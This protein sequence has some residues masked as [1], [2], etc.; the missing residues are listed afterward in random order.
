MPFGEDAFAAVMASLGPW[1]TH[2]SLAVAVSG[3]ADSLAL[4][5]LAARWARARGGQVVGLT[6]DHG[7]RPEAAAEAAQVGLWLAARQILHVILPWIG[8]KPL[9]GLQEAAR[10]A[11]YGL[12]RQ[13]CAQRGI[14]HLLV[15]HQREDQAETL[16]LR[17]GRASGLD[18]LAAMSA[19][20]ALPECRLLRPLLEVPRAALESWLRSQGQE[21][22]DDPSNHSERY[23]RVRLRNLAPLLEAEGLSAEAL[24]SSARRLGRARVALEQGV[25]DLSAHCLELQ[26][27]GYGWLAPDP[28]RAAPED[29]RLRL[30]A[31]LCRMIGGGIHPPRQ[32]RL[33]RL[34]AELFTGLT[35][36]RSFDGCLL[37]PS[38]G[39]ILVCREP[40]RVGAALA[41]TGARS[42]LWDDR[43]SLTLTGEGGGRIEAL[44]ADGWAEIKDRVGKNPPPRLAALT[45]PALKDA[46]GVSA[47][48]YLRYNRA[49]NAALCLANAAFTP[50]R[51]LV[52]GGFV[53]PTR[54]VS[55]KNGTISSPFTDCQPG[56]VQAGRGKRNGLAPQ[57][58]DPERDR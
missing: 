4:T 5:L 32:D 54:L 30:L 27:A 6:V 11:R 20:T 51:A 57:A 8:E 29:L 25:A 1:E 45:F 24:S 47:V 37:T 48:P 55:V 34:E 22:I 14:L 9:N 46:E 49:G 15:A 23:G 36:R 13:A 40:G 39:R 58:P 41:V 44:G 2:P 33:E 17:L 38:R 42:L 52:E 18:G 35:A 43:H 28:W 16:L 10:Q 26:L 31:G 53:P 50:A 21:W 19:V 56:S 7:L 3:G 12:L